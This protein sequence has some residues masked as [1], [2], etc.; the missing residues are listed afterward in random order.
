LV[1]FF[2]PILA[3]AAPEVFRFDQSNQN[4]VIVFEDSQAAE[5]QKA[6]SPITLTFSF[7]GDCTLGAT[8]G[9]LKRKNGFKTFIDNHSFAYPFE[10]LTSLFANDDLTVINLEGVFSDTS[11]GENKKKNF[12]FRGPTEYVNILLEGSVEAVNIAN[13]HTQDYG[14]RG[15]TS[16]LETLDHHQL[17]YAG[18]GW[19]SIFSFEGIKVGLGG[20]GSNWNSQKCEN[21]KKEIQ[22]LKEK[23]CSIII[24][25]LH[26][27]QEYAY[28]HNKRQE[29]LAR[30]LIDQGVDIVIG[31]HP[32]VV[33]GVEQYN[34]GYVFYSLGNCSFGGNSKPKDL[35]ALVAQVHFT[36]DLKQKEKQILPCLHPIHISGTS[37]HNNYQPVYV[38]N[39]NAEEILSLVQIDSNV[40][41][42]PYAEDLGALL[43]AIDVSLALLTK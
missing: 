6:T 8:E 18:N 16:T 29:Q 13:N 2:L 15:V 30:F 42:S 27:G 41:I 20:T 5:S 21:L 17:G 26:A 28:S 24:Y 25:S 4:Q 31:H 33:Q 9:M 39:E 7:A 1:L 34:N 32:H 43:P 22:L 12:A 10:Q 3:Q 36:I 37:P 19:L 40:S 11:K 35:R 38:Q 14:T 23:N